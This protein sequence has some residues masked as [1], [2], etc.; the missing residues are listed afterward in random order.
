[1]SVAAAAIERLAAEIASL[2]RHAG[3]EVAIDLRDVTDRSDAVVLKPPGAWSANRS[4]RLIRAADAWMAVNLP[5][6]SDLEAVPAWIGTSIGSDPWR[7]IIRRVAQSPS[8]TLLARAR[9]LGLP[10]CRVGETRAPRLAAP[11]RRMAPGTGRARGACRW[12]ELRVVDLS[13][14]WAGP[15]CGHVLI[16]A[17]AQ[18]TK[19][20]HI[21]RPD[22]T[23]LSPGKFFHRLNH[24]KANRS[25][26][27]GEPGDIEALRRLMATADVVITSAR[28]RAFDQLGLTPASLF[29]VNPR[30][31][32]VAITGHGWL[33]GGADRVGFGDDAAAAGGLVRWSRDGAPRFCGDALADPI[34]GL[35]AAVGALRAVRRGGGILVDAALARSA[36]GAVS[37]AK[38]FFFEEKYQ[39]TFNY[40]GR[41]R[42][43]P[44]EPP[45]GCN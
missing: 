22:P 40:C 5:R 25:L 16:Q 1:M 24:G 17:G 29:A 43:G 13:S 19:I 39:K 26:D 31:T 36:A 9:L 6:A 44:F 14:L 7:A 3:R 2:T 33:G 38:Q 8:R 11:L 21:G 45:A 35:A 4:C 20:E 23:R 34:T 41:H 10:V 12:S 37:E 28:A 30:L 42:I 27:F 18:V 15:L 32:W